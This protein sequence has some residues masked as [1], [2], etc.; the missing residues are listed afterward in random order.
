[1]LVRAGGLLCALPHQTTGC[2]EPA[3]RPFHLRRIVPWRMPTPIPGAPSTLILGVAPLGDD[4]GIEHI[5]TVID[6]AAALG[7]LPSGSPRPASACILTY[8]NGDLTACFAADALLHRVRLSA[9]SSPGA[10]P[11]VRAQIPPADDRTDSVP[12]QIID[13]DHL[14]AH[15]ITE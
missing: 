11:F 2:A 15:L 9:P 3:L 1:A 4:E 12:W 13:V 6:L 7:Q 5:E 8:S 10:I 14:I